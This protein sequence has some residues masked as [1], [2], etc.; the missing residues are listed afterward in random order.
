M[1]S[2]I[3]SNTK[4]K[5]LF[6]VLCIV[7]AWL[8]Y[9]QLTEKKNLI[10]TPSSHEQV[11]FLET[12]NER[13]SS[14]HKVYFCL[15]DRECEYL[16]VCIKVPKD[17]RTFWQQD[18]LT[19]LIDDEKRKDYSYIGHTTWKSKYVI[20]LLDHVPEFETFQCMYGGSTCEAFF[21]ADG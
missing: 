8:I 2:V 15:Y 9:L 16:Q 11:I 6:L 1:A 17:D 3:E 13:L 19:F 18:S 12:K 20:I 14:K 21:P 5:L 4:Y 7:I 10:M